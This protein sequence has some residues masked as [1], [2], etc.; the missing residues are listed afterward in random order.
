MSEKIAFIGVG[1]MGGNMARR[2][3]DC[4][5]RVTAVYDTHAPAAAALARELGTRHVRKLAD[6]T[7]PLYGFGPTELRD[8]QMVRAIRQ[9]RDEGLLYALARPETFN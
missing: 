4:G 6:A 3:K 1:R 2:L 8:G 5:Y 7:A 9:G